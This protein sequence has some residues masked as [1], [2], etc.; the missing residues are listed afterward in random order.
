MGVDWIII[1]RSS[2]EIKM[3]LCLRQLCLNRQRFLANNIRMLS[4]TGVLKA[5]DPNVYIP[6]RFL[7]IKDKQKRFQ[8]DD[9]L[10]VHQKGGARDT[11]LYNLT[12]LIVLIGLAEWCRVVWT[13]AYPKWETS[14]T[15]SR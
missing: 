12:A 2:I 1:L 8:I 13:L 9:G 7:K 4:S 11:M 6:E 14:L 10:R 15:K 3:S 5:Q